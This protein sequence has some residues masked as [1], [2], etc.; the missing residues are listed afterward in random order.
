MGTIKMKI[1]TNPFELKENRYLGSKE[2]VDF[3]PLVFYLGGEIFW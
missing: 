2:L 3:V 1:E